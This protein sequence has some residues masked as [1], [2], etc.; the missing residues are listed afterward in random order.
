MSSQMDLTA[1][2]MVWQPPMIKLTQHGWDGLDDGKE[3]ILFVNPAVISRIN[4]VLSW[5]NNPDGTKTEA[6]AVTEVHCCHYVCHVIEAP[7]IVAMMRDKALGH[8]SKLKALP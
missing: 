7:E 2:Q 5:Q 1:T 4:R 3:T 8:E 6:K